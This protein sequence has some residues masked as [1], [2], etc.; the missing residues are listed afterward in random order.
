MFLFIKHF[1]FD[2]VNEQ[3]LSV[4]IGDGEGA[5]NGPEQLT[6]IMFGVVELVDFGEEV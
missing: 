6:E 5:V 4:I 2:L 3:P 1:V